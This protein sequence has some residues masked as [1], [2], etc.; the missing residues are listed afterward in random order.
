MEKRRKRTQ[1]RSG[2]C[3]SSAHLCDGFRIQGFAAVVAV[4]VGEAGVLAGRGGAADRGALHLLEG[5][6]A[7]D[8]VQASVASA[9]P[10]FWAVCRDVVVSTPHVPGAEVADDWGA[11][12]WGASVSSVTMLGGMHHAVDLAGAGRRATGGW[13][14]SFLMPTE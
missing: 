7:A 1:R 9:A 2:H 12:L 10:A 4:H 6:V 3:S 14:G 8:V 11:K 13:V 5:L